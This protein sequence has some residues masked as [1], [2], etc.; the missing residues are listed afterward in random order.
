MVAVLAKVVCAVVENASGVIFV[1]AD[2]EDW[3]PGG[4]MIAPEADESYIREK[5]QTYLYSRRVT[6]A[7]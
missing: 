5:F 1:K 3:D 2:E 6:K 7:K 4:V